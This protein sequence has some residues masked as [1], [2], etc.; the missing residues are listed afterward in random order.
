M[1]QQ[2]K[3]GEYRRREKT[4][5]EKRNGKKQC[6]VSSTLQLFY[7]VSQKGQPLPSG[8]KLKRR[9]IPGLLIFMG[10]K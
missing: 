5:F 9:V 2:N 8:T 3:L 1:D 4:N 10:G 7:P 6:T